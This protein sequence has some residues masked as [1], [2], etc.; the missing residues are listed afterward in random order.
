MTCSHLSTPMQCQSI[1]FLAVRRQNLREVQLAAACGNSYLACKA[2]P[3]SILEQSEL[4]LLFK[5]RR[6]YGGGSHRTAGAGL[7]AITHRAAA[8]RAA[9][10]GAIFRILL[11]AVLVISAQVRQI[12]LPRGREHMG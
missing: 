3:T 6:V 8:G 1:S 7:A 2:C 4:G 12:P 11:L 5:T 10:H 9:I